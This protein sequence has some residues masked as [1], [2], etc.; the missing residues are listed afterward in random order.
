MHSRSVLKSLGYAVTGLSL[1]V[2]LSVTPVLSTGLFSSQQVLAQDDEDGP[3][4]PPSTR[5][6][7]TLSRPVFTRI[8]DVQELR[9]EEA[10]D[11]ALEILGELREMANEDRLNNYEQYMMYVFY[12]SIAM[13]RENFEDAADY[14]DAA[15]DLPELSAT[16]QAQAFQTLG[17]L[18]FMLERYEGALTAFNNYL[19][20]AEDPDIGI[21]LRKATAL[22]VLE[23]YEEALPE[24]LRNMELVRAQGEPIPENTYGLLRSIY[25]NLDDYEAVREVLREMIVLF[26]NPDEW[27]QLAQVH[28]QLENFDRQAYTYYLADL[29]EYL[30]SSQQLMTLGY[31][32]YN[33]DN[34]WGASQV[35]AEGMANGAIEEN[36]DNLEFLATAY[37]T[38]RED[39]RA[40]EPLRRAA[41][42]SGEGPL[43]YRLGRI[44]M[45][46]RDYENAVEAMDN[47]LDAGGVD[48]EDQLY[49]TQATAYYLLDRYDEA[50]EAARNA[51]EADE[52]SADSAQSMVTSFQRAK[53]SYESIQR[54]REELAEWL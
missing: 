46:L 6:A 31:L 9:D 2:T 42:M 1:A 35:I 12:A 54:R 40:L 14:W 24:V 43:Y 17:Q 52:R 34:P 5:Q 32:L 27:T 37:Q 45:N 51:G 33:N 19:R 13:D 44:Y 53:E 10:Y 47:A 26:D 50:I 49:Q 28:S 30:T 11:E 38:A 7:N 48:R 18:R 29:K 21:Y 25:F 15:L 36:A 3:R 20:V 41:E 39:E 4:P 22:Y 8:E 23:R 16:Q